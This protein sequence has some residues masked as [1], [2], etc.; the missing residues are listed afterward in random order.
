[1]QELRDLLVLQQKLNQWQTRMVFYSDMLDE[2]EANR[3]LE[4]NFIVQQEASN[5]LDAMNIERE[6]LLATIN[7][8]DQNEDFLSMLQGTERKRLQRIKHAENNLLLLQEAGRDV[9]QEREKLARIR[10]LLLWNAG[11]LF[12]ERIWRARKILAELDRHIVDATKSHL[13]IDEIVDKGFDQ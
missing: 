5:K 6:K 7:N 13:R 12:A 3:L 9:A 8:I 11:E 10:G 2:R 4:M 1:M